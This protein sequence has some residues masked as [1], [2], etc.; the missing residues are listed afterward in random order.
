M[1]ARGRVSLGRLALLFGA[2]VALFGCDAGGLL[3][4]EDKNTEPPPSGHSAT[5]IVNGGTLAK[6][7]KYKM[8]YTLGQPSPHQGVAKGANGERMNGGLVGAT[9]GK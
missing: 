3:N 5:D 2:S 9:Q 8:I 6:N 4:A 1:T 7:D